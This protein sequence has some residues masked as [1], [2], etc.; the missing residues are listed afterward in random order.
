MVF[1]L[2]CI[3][4]NMKNYAER[5]PHPRLEQKAEKITWSQEQRTV[6]GFNEELR[7]RNEEPFIKSPAIDILQ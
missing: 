4:N 6:P 3:D 5:S 1:F 2:H 7:T